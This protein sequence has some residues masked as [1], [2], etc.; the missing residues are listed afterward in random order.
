MFCRVF[1]SKPVEE[2]PKKN[3]SEGTEEGVFC[4]LPRAY[5]IN[6]KGC[7]AEIPE[8][9]PCREERD[10]NMSAGITGQQPTNQLHSTLLANRSR[11]HESG[12]AQCIL[13]PTNMYLKYKLVRTTH[14]SI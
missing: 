7:E 6:R 4:F 3:I 9:I 2:K 11:T 1:A 5:V 13:S 12:K 10:K 14:L 8:S